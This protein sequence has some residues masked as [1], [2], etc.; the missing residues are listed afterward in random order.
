MREIVLITLAADPETGAID[1]TA[2]FLVQASDPAR[3]GLYEREPEVLAQIQPGERDAT[4]EAEW[5]GDERKFGTRVTL[6]LSR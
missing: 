4:F 1:R 2:P 3:R 5:M 6:G